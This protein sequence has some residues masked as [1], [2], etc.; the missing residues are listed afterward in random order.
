MTFATPA[1]WWARPLNFL[2]KCQ[3]K[4]INR[5]LGAGARFFDLR[6]GRNLMARHGL[7][8]Y[9][10]SA[11]GALN[12]LNLYAETHP[13]ENVC[14]RIVL[15]HARR[16]FYGEYLTRQ[17]EAQARDILATYTSLKFCGAFRKW[18]W[19]CVVEPSY[20]VSYVSAYASYL[21]WKGFPYVPALYAKWRNRKTL[22][23]NESVL[24]D[25]NKVLMVDFI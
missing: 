4:D 12:L 23:D 18:D 11:Y 19:L 25:N 3:V 9:D 10:L 5:Q 21:G 17:F 14:F 24:D 6:V 1:H 13:G 7:M 20:R 15:E 8:K 22:K 16:P 2:A